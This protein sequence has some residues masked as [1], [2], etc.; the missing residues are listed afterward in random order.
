MLKPWIKPFF[1]LAGL[2]DGVLG[3]IF[4][5][6]P[7]QIFRMAAVTPPNHY[8]YVQFPALLMVVFGIMFLRV[9]ADP[10]ARRELMLYGMGLKGSYVFL[11][12]WYE[13]RGG[14]P[15]LW[16]PWAWIDG[17]SLVLFYLAWRSTARS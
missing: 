17:F 2:Y 8:G 9:A 12:L 11:I 14:I 5:L 15:M 16:I 13:L 10:V 1:V 3:V 6:F 4:F 7:A